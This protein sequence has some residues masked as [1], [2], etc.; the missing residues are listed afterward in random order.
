[1]AKLIS[2]LKIGDKVFVINHLHWAFDIAEVIDVL[3]TVIRL[4]FYFNDTSDN[5]YC[6]WKYQES[7]HIAPWYTFFTD[8]VE[9]LEEFKRTLKWQE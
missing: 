3:N 1:M 7:K 6:M 9:A 8:E 4:Q 5:T 2:D